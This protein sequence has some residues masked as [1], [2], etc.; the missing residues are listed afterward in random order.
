MNRHRFTAGVLLGMALWAGVSAQTA[1][2]SASLA[3][4]GQ[5]PAA[6]AVAPVRPV[7][8]AAPPV[9]AFNPGGE[10]R[11]LVVADKET[12]LSAPAPG[13]IASVTVRLGDEVQAG[14]VMVS[15]DCAE[16][17]ARRDAA[18]AELITAR[19]Q[20]ESK[21]KL[22]SLDS[23]AEVEVEL[24]AANVDRADAQ[25]RVFDAQLV[26]CQFSAPFAGRVARV[27]VKPGQSVSVGAPVVDV[28]SLVGLRARLN[29]P[30]RWLAVVKP[31][32][33]MDT[34]IEEIARRYSM[35][36][37]RVSSRVDAVSQTVELEAE[38][39]GAPKDLLPGMSGR[40][41]LVLG[42]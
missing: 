10:A 1:A 17:Q 32:V 24:A 34:E 33:R 4:A 16:S 36:V 41:W 2:P 3:P 23:A 13:R 22:Q 6:P 39:E 40:A 18:K 21:L 9:R 5:K 25:V 14:Q 29:V 37:S 19:L 38:F 11:L 35:R 8:D 30:S 15:F 27:H 28:V 26:Q 42:K 12:S 20:H 31:G 7:V